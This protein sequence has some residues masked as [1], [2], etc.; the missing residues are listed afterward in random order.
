[1]YEKEKH[2]KES[3]RKKLNK[4]RKEME[5]FDKENTHVNSEKNQAILKIKNSFMCK[6]SFLILIRQNGGITK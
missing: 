3:L 2:K 1:M 5:E 6:L 4:C